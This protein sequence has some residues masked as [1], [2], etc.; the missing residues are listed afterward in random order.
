MN[1]S[2]PHKRAV[3]LQYDGEHA[4]RVTAKGDG[5]IGDQIIQLACENGVPLHADPELAAVLANIPLG[6]EIPDDLYV[7]IAEILAFIYY[8]EGEQRA[9][10]ARKS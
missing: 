6:E 3:A 8:L 10:V 7:A 1:G 4:P 2:Q 9:A 5:Y